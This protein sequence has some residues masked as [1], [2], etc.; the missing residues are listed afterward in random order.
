MKAIGPKVFKWSN[1]TQLVSMLK[2]LDGRQLGIIVTTA[3]GGAYTA[4]AAEVPKGV[5]TGAQALANHS[6]KI[7][8]SFDEVGE[9]MQAAEDFARGWLA[10]SEPAERCPCDEIGARRRKAP[11]ARAAET[12][13]SK[14]DDGQCW[15]VASGD[16]GTEQGALMY[17]ERGRHEGDDH[18][19]AKVPA[20]AKWSVDL[21]A[22][23]QPPLTD[24]RP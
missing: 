10:S 13:Q 7:V 12:R 15:A 3:N 8:G 11:R 19:A 17:C 9:A 6:H 16:D 2:H 20:G 1:V 4:S 23:L 21:N 5:K 18:Q 14:L 22:V 24:K